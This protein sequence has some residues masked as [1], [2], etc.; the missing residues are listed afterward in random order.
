MGVFVIINLIELIFRNLGFGRIWLEMEEFEQNRGFD[1]ICLLDDKKPHLGFACSS[2]DFLFSCV[3]L[4]RIHI[5]GALSPF[6][7]TYSVA[8]KYVA[9][10][11]WDLLMVRRK[12]DE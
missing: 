10:I 9:V 2:L 5:G 8:V 11:Y 12:F 7:F 3:F 4:C 1:L 6:F